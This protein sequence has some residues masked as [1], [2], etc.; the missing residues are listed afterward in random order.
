MIRDV[1]VKTRYRDENGKE[2]EI[3]ITITGD[4]IKQTVK[5]RMD[6]LMPKAQIID[7]TEEN[8]DSVQL[9]AL[10]NRSK[11]GTAK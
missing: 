1:R 11:P 6:T 7:M 2:Q 8:P 5:R 10:G 9:D 3:T 4:Q